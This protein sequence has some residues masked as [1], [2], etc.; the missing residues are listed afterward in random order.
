[1]PGYT[2]TAALNGGYQIATADLAG[3]GRPDLIALASGMDRIVWYENPG[4]EQHTL[5]EGVRTPINLDVW[6]GRIAM[7]EAF[8]PDPRRSEGII[9]VLEPAGDVRNPWRK[10]E[11]DRLT[12]SHRL[13]WADLDGSGLKVLV[14]APLAGAS[15]APPNY[16]AH[17]PLVCYRPEN[18]KREVIWDGPRGVMHGIFICDWDGDGRDE[19]LTASFEGI[20][21]LDLKGGKWTVTRLAQGSPGP[22]PN[23]GTSDVSV[24]QLRGTR[25][26][27]AIEPWHG[28]ELVVYT[29]GAGGWRRRVVDNTFVDGHALL[30]ADVDG[31]GRDEIVAG[32]RGGGKSVYLYRAETASGERWRRTPLDEGGMGAASCAVADFDGDGRPQIACIDS[33]SVKVYA[34]RRDFGTA[35][36]R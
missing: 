16:D 9:S 24:G 13:R 4:W 12:T 23:G 27:A 19:I 35:K 8:S 25:F 7:A 6:G 1:M 20:H 14:N 30:T 22:W 11:I 33:M 5:A 36:S 21:L 15:A 31:D 2:V 28:H 26:L 32:C 3:N 18:W 29:E 34:P 10:R 17:V